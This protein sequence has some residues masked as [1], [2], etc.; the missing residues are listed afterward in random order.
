MEKLIRTKSGHPNNFSLIGG[1]TIGKYFLALLRLL[2]GNQP[3]ENL[4]ILVD[5]LSASNQC[6]RRTFNYCNH[7]MEWK[8]LHNILK[9]LHFSSAI[10]L[11]LSSLRQTIKLRNNTWEVRKKAKLNNNYWH[12]RYPQQD[13][14]VK[15][16][17]HF[18]E[19][20]N[21]K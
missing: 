12:L 3:K 16:A 2:K 18:T 1:N 9:F 14:L 6:Q 17:K 8:N 10:P 13:Q 4:K 11:R 7:R 21:W 5:W 15:K 20:F 19:K